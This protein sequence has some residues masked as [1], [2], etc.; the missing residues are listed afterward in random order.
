[1]PDIITDEIT[2]N[3][4]N[5][6]ND[7]VS[8]AD[9]WRLIP[10][11]PTMSDKAINTAHR[12]NAMGSLF[13]FTKIVLRKH[14]LTSTLHKMLC[15]HLEKTYLKELLEIP[16]DHFKSTICSESAPMWWALPFTNEDSEYMEALGY[17]DEWIRWMRRT[18][19]QDTRTLL[20][21]A[22]AVNAEKL[23]KRIDFHYDNNSFFI[24]LF[25]TIQKDT[26]CNWSVATKTH[27]RTKLSGAAQGEGTYDFIGVG[28]AL[29]SRH[30]DRVI[31]DDLVGR[32][33]LESEKVMGD[34]IDYHKL[35]VGAFDSDPNSP[36]NDNDEIIVGNR[37]AYYDLNS[38]I[39]KDE[40]RFHIN[41]HSALGGC[42][43]LH[44][45]GIPIFPEEF[46]TKKL[47]KIKE[48]LGTY[49]FSC[50]FLNRPT[51]PG[52]TKFKINNI[53]YFNYE[54]NNPRE[55][56][57]P[58]SSTGKPS[59]AV[60]IVHEVKGTGEGAEVIKDVFPVSLTRFMVIDP[61]HSDD[62]GRS[63][64]AIV[65]TGVR[66]NPYWTYLLESFCNHQQGEFVD[67][68]FN[69]AEKWK[70]KVVHLETIAGQRWLKYHLDV[71]M[72][73][74]RMLGKW[75]FQIEP[76]KTS[77]NKDAKIQRIESLEPLFN[78]QGLWVKRTGDESFIKEYEEYPYSL[79]RDILDVLGYSS[80]LWSGSAYSDDEVKNF[81][82]KHRSY[83]TNRRAGMTGY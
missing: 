2:F 71:A 74:R 34:T 19:N 64:N 78:R 70:M 32:E 29:Q 37:W 50:Q 40:P 38:H 24:K 77:H 15:N 31:Q 53:R 13:Y 12:L 80:E 18:H 14:R 67:E 75:T 46:T 43:D 10:I 73:T 51:P 9:K 22:N 26:T 39:R 68:I 36:D 81:L 83:A 8:Y 69:L 55:V 49:F 35:L 30:Y 6:L 54:M 16:R 11:N 3:T 1:M 33:A 57:S 62:S 56:Y 41:S 20:V 47:D 82:S 17:S 28:G 65:V 63:R 59:P 72:E 76:L 4:D 79:T 60:K 42:C 61:K 48:R 5:E 7:G 25:P 21:S 44:P 66:S 58:N 23:G 27:K 52:E 45:T